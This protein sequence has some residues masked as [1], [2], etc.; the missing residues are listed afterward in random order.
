MKKVLLIAF[1]F[2]TIIVKTNA[3]VPV[4]NTVTPN[5][6][7]LPKLSKFELTIDL[8]AGYT[9]PYDYSDIDVQCIF[10]SPSMKKDTVDG[11]YMQD[12]TLN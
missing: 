11:F 7:T 9:N 2:A 10:T 8:T 4:F 3:Q 1:V 5:S 6:T 12:Y